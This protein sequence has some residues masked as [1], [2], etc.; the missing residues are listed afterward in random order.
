M[1]Q[2]RSL[3]LEKALKGLKHA[4]GT[5]IDCKMECK[6]AL[7]G[8]LQQGFGAGRT[9]FESEMTEIGHFDAEKLVLHDLCQKAE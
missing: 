6:N 2:N 3:V 9:I 4:L 8:I 7:N 5:D 1:D